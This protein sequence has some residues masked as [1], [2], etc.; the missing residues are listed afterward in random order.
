VQKRIIGASATALS[1]RSLSDG[2]ARTYAWALVAMLW[3]ISFLNYADR[4]VLSAV[5][6]QIRSEFQLTPPQLALLSSSFLWVYAVAA[7]LAGYLGDRFS[8]KRVILAGLVTWSLLTF[9]TPF[10]GTFAIFVLLRAFTG[11]GEAS[12]Y[13]AGTALIS[14]YHGPET[15]SRAL[16]IHQTA[17]FA[18]GGIGTLIAAALA[19]RFQWRLPFYAYGAI[20]VLIAVVVAAMMRDTPPAVKR[21]AKTEQG[22]F[23]F[24]LRRRSALMLYAVFFFATSVSAGV[25]IWAPTFFHDTMNFSLTQATFY[26]AATINLAGFCAVLCGGTL[27]DWAAARFK[28]GRFYVLA[29]GLCLAAVFLLPFGLLRNANLLGLCLLLAGF[30]KGLFDG[31]IYAAMHD[32]VPPFARAT[33]VGMMT[34]LGFVGAGLSPLVIAW[35]GEAFGL[36]NAISLMALLYLIGVILL[37][38]SRRVAIADMEDSERRIAATA[39]PP[40]A[41]Q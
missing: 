23:A 41:A 37:L 30:S 40:E 10:A 26:G 24:V 3:V 21:Q 15:R 13:P 28:V 2:P 29:G 38:L 32:V 19:D 25:T 35:L 36:G 1:G 4:S 11:L 27:A 33:A 14:D 9:L 12:Y 34:T 7:S 6:P 22:T 16:A 31:C 5:M 39:A 18:G 8:R 17:V 20:G